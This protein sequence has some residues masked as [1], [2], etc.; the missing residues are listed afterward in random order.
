MDNIIQERLMVP[1]DVKFLGLVRNFILNALHQSNR[2]SPD[3][4][5][6][7][8]LAID[9]ACTNII[10]HS[11]EFRKSGYIDIK[12]MLDPQKVQVVL[13]NDGK[14]FN[15][16]AVKPPDILE[17]IKHKRRK[18]FGLFIIKQVMDEIIYSV[19]KRGENELTMVKY[20]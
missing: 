13:L 17:F 7:I 10:E 11:Y 5:N 16:E 6:K 19:N 15:P 12:L 14:N 20:V 2:I 4:E 1:S 9:E 18:G 3:K 8:V